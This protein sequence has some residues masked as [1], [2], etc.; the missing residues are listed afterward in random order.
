MDD[1]LAPRAAVEERHAPAAASPAPLVR[2]SVVDQPGSVSRQRR[3]RRPVRRHDGL[4]AGGEIMTVNTVSTPVKAASVLAPALVGGE[5]LR[6]RL[7][8]PSAAFRIHEPH[9][10]IDGSGRAALRRPRKVGVEM[11]GSLQPA[12]FPCAQR[13]RVIRRTDLPVVAEEIRFSPRLKPAAREIEKPLPATSRDASIEERLVARLRQRQ[14]RAEVVRAGK[15]GRNRTDEDVPLRID[16]KVPAVK[17]L[18]I[19]EVE[20]VRHD[21]KERMVDVGIWKRQVLLRVLQEKRPVAREVNAGEP[22][23]SASLAFVARNVEE[24]EAPVV[25]HR[26]DREI[27]GLPVPSEHIRPQD[28]GN[29]TRC[30]DAPFEKP[31]RLGTAGSAS[32]V[33]C[34]HQSEKILHFLI[35]RQSFR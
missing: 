25:G 4:L 24:E 20:P 22:P 5:V 1:G 17:P 16:G 13:E 35:Y 27:Q 28:K 10:R 33:T 32:H 19:D 12:P 15:L 34:H 18:P 7:H 21:V 11:R 6:L 31:R 30:I 3:M 2:R 26:L 23:R 29:D 14:V 8:E 9:A